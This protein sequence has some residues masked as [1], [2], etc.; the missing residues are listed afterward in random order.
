[1]VGGREGWRGGE[2]MA[3]RIV[4]QEFT[5]RFMKMCLILIE[6]SINNSI[7]F[8]LFKKGFHYSN[9]KYLA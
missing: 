9:L 1:M 2:F 3:L 5:K 8:F 7:C 4:K 6:N